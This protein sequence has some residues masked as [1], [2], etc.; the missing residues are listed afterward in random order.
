MFTLLHPTE[1]FISFISIDG[2]KHEVWPDSGE[3]LFEGGLRPRGNNL[4]LYHDKMTCCLY[5]V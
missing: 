3:Q 1:V 2:S 5:H 4:L